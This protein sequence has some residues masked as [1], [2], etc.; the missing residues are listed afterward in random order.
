MPEVKT[1]RSASLRALLVLSTVLAGVP[2]A[3]WAQDVTAQTPGQ[4]LPSPPNGLIEPEVAPTITQITVVGA[5]RLEPQTVLSYTRLRPGD[6]YTD[7]AAD[8]AIKDLLNT[9]LFSDVGVGFANGVVTIQVQEN[10]VV[11]RIVLEGN[12]RLKNDKIL[13]EIRLKPREIYTASKVRADTARIIELYRRQGRFAA[14]VDPKR[15]DL[16]QNRVDV[17]FEVKEG[18]KSKVRQINIIGNQ[19]FSD[20]KLRGEMVTKQSSLLRFLSSNTTY[21]PD[22]LAFD[23]QKLRQ[24][25]LSEGYADFRVVSAVAELTPDKQDFVITFVVEEGQKYKF[26]D[27]KVESALRD[28]QPEVIRPLLSVREG[29]TFDATKVENSVN[30]IQE[31]AGLFGYAFAKVEPDFGRNPDTLTMDMTFQVAD[32]QRVYIERVDI[33]GNT[34]TEDKVIRREFRLAEGDAFNS[35][36]VKRSAARINSLGFFQEGLEIT[37]EPGS[38]PDRIVL[39]A[40]VQ[41]KPTGNL[42]LSAGYS[43]L[44]RLLF[45]ASIEQPNFRG[46]G[47]LLRL[48]GSYSRFAKSLELGFTEPYLF[49]TN[50]QLGGQIFRRD[51]NSFNFQNNRRNTTFSQVSTGASVSVGVPLTEYFYALGRYNLQFDDLSLD[52][53]SFFTNGQ[54][55]PLLAGRYLCD[56]LGKRTTSSLGYT[57][58][59]NATD[60]RLRPSRGFRASLSQD[61]AGLGGDVNYLKSQVN[62]AQFFPVGGGFIFSLKG[63][64]GYIFSFDGS[65]GPG[66]DAIRLND[67]FFLGEGKLRGFDIRGVGPR[68]LRFPALTAENGDLLLNDDGTPQLVTDRN[69]IVDDALGGNA[70]YLA[71]AELEIPLGDGARELG[72]RPSI[73]VDVGSLFS[74][75]R[76]L[77]TTLLSDE[78]RAIRD[79]AGNLLYIQPEVRDA[80]G[81]VTQEMMLV[82]NRGPDGT[83]ALARNPRP[84]V[85]R[86]FGDSPSPRLSVGV[87]VNWNSPFGPLRIDLARAI[88]SREG[89]DKKLFTFNVGTA[90]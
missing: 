81:M 77:L 24:F 61:F 41:E 42:T 3:G 73:F 68:V 87:G 19:A 56:V 52:R 16:D 59:Y 2:A 62:A 21:D 78:E 70:Y 86:F 83:F 45:Q 79:E 49:D 67:R 8:A 28:F 54:C 46:K 69:R 37:Q 60:S 36:L 72:L 34:L 51:Y 55:D 32:A 27:V 65:P 58:D 18:P 6:A 90:F 22:R 47:Q 63:E 40:N 20:G 80:N 71:R 12:K 29:E 38:S 82:P 84:F 23:Q 76:P 26:G 39:Q 53:E 11:N 66:R 4:S 25:Y 5:Q 15:V 13:P 14:T 57:L 9:E 30:A 74:V 17:I 31:A 75:K 1:R 48:S 88:L 64:G 35:V 85:E 44:E 33:N 50:L 7:A 43:S 89:D 10:P